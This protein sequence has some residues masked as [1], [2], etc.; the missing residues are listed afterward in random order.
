MKG[1]ECFSKLKNYAEIKIAWNK[2]WSQR[3]D[4]MNWDGMST[5][6]DTWCFV[7]A[8]A[9]KEESYQKCGAKNEHSIN[10]I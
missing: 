10:T 4:S 7:E 6:G 8:K 5:I 1:I 3:G 9:H 2:F